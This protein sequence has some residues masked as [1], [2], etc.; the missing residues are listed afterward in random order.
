MTTPS[1]LIIE[2]DAALRA[3]ETRLA[4]R[5]GFAVRSAADGRA[6]LA[7]ALAQP[8]DVVVSDLHMPGLNGP[9]LL[10]K[11]R[12][13]PSMQ[14]SP[15]LVVTGDHSDAVRQ[16]LVSAG[17]DDVIIKPFP[18]ADFRRHL[19]EA[20]QRQGLQPVPRQ[21]ARRTRI[22]PEPSSPPP[23]ATPPAPPLSAVPMPPGL[24]V[25]LTA[26]LERPGPDRLDAVRNHIQRVRA[27]STL[28]ARASGAP[29]LLVQQIQAYSGLHDVG[30][31][32]LP[33]RIL[34]K[35]DTFS[36]I[37]RQ[38]MQ[39]HVHHGADMLQAAG[40]PKV[41]V[42]IARHHHER[43]DG[44]GYPHGLAE[45]RIPYAARVVAV[46]DFYDALRT[47]RPYRPALG[48]EQANQRLRAHAGTHLDPTLVARFLEH[49][50]QIDAIYRHHADPCLEAD[51][52][53][54]R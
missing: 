14:G 41:A 45:D 8:P 54:W 5:A 30:K 51:L 4:E 42:Q 53:D 40:L 1:V 6:G 15:I 50:P 52:E 2:D 3:L 35:R 37:E 47:A 38:L 17:A 27:L 21:R 31:S 13:L 28:L 49:V 26:A 34:Q 39:S 20:A 22:K 46:T 7:S 11:L 18:P 9:E 29:D 10:R 32:G 19:V 36:S 16:D 48:P 25:M 24:T 33:D 12:E 44:Q 43:W 23:Q